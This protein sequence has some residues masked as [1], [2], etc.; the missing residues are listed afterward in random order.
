M[1]GSSK[2]ALKEE[3]PTINFAFSTAVITKDVKKGDKLNLDN[4]WVKRPGIGEIKPIDFKKILG[5]KVKKDL[6]KDY[7]LKWRDLE[8]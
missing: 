1:R 7:H 3:K 4:V 2:S 5:K 8:K 6:F